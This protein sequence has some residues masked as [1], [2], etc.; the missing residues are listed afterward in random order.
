MFS[1]FSAHT[2]PPSL[3]VQLS[4]NIICF[5]S[6]FS[7]LLVACLMNVPELLI[8]YVLPS[9][10]HRIRKPPRLP[11]ASLIS[12]FPSSLIPLPIVYSSFSLSI[13]F[14]SCSLPCRD[15]SL[16]VVLTFSISHNAF[17]PSSPI[18]LPVIHHP[19][20]SF[21]FY[22]FPP[23]LSKSSTFNV[24][25]ALRISLNILTPSSPSPFPVIFRCHH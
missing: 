23:S 17:A 24:V 4:T 18:Q 8:C 25:F 20:I 19:S 16:N 7:L 6:L 22:V 3:C 1:A 10:C 15:S 21:S 5:V 2:I 14:Y 9:I 13:F 11:H 12:F